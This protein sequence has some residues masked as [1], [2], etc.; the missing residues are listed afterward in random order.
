[1]NAAEI[2]YERRPYEGHIDGSMKTFIDLVNTVAAELNVQWSFAGGFPR[3]LYKG[4]QWND[5]DVCIRDANHARRRLEEMGVLV[6]GQAEAGEIPHDM[7]CD[8]YSF[9]KSGIPIHWI[10]A[11]DEWAFAPVRFDFGIN[12]I[13]LKPDG[14]FYA[15]K[16]AWRDLDKGIVRKTTDRMTS[17]LATRAIRFAC[18]YDMAIDSDLNKQIMEQVKEPMGTDIL[19]RNCQKMI[20]DGVGERCF[21]MMGKRGFPHMEDCSTIEDYVRKLNDMII[22]GEGHR[23]D[24]GG[25]Y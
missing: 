18:K 5:Y 20:E 1:M 2:D 4:T 16:Y 23:E 3:D 14:F 15:P 12:Q 13:C 11:D 17:N 25:G 9:S 24:H 6:L 10:D 7:Y 19:L 8:P 22:R 21:K